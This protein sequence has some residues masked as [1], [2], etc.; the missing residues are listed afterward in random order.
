MQAAD[1]YLVNGSD[2]P[3][4]LFDLLFVSRL[5]EDELEEIAGEEETRNGAVRR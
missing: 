1:F 3:L 4:K 2:S 5:S